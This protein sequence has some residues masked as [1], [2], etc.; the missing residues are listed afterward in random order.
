MTA[1]RRFPFIKGAA[2]SI[3]STTIVAGPRPIV[4]LL[5]SL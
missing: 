2:V 1:A 4:G 3:S 5:I